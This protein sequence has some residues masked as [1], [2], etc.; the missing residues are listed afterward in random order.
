MKTN[1][2]FDQVIYINPAEAEQDWIHVRQQCSLRG[3][4]VSRVE[5]RNTSVIPNTCSLT[6]AE[7]AEL[8][9]FYNVIR[10]ANVDGLSRLLILSNKI[11]LCKGYAAAAERVFEEL[12]R[13]WDAAFLGWTSYQTILPIK[14][15]KV[16]QLATTVEG[17]FAIAINNSFYS[18]FL[19][20]A[21]VPNYNLNQY[22]SR[23]AFYLQLYV[24]IPPLIV[25][26]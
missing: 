1:E 24:V 13:G 22:I 10:Q 5:S 20:D 15:D 9:T 21:K 18:F 2:F 6:R 25:L 23:L 19:D 26:A 4:V 3:F 17:C 8:L 7:L 16:V 14:Q 11:N 12:P